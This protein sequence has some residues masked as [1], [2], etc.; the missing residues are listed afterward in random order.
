MIKLFIDVD[1]VITN[2]IKKFCEIYNQKYSKH[3]D[4]TFS[5]C[6]KVR[7]WNFTDQGPLIKSVDEV[8]EFF[9]LPEFYYKAAYIDGAIDSINKLSN[10]YDISIV[11]MGSP[12]NLAYK[13]EALKRKI[14]IM[15]Y[16]GID[17][18]KH[19]DKRKVDMSDGIFID[20]V[21]KNLITSNADKKICFGEP[22]PWNDDWCDER[23]FNW[24]EVL[25]VLN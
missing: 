6:T 4:F 11:T 8:N 21:S 10:K 23:C 16:Y 9:D 19:T 1:G 15:R 12:I 24:T 25:N 13:Y 22:M 7:E 5:D 18:S 2:T 17:I 14:P 20:D 3:P